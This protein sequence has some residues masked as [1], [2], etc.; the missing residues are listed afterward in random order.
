EDERPRAEPGHERR[1]HRTDGVGG[2]AEDQRQLAGP[3]TLID[4]R[5]CA[6]DEQQEED[7]AREGHAVLTVGILR[8]GGR[9]CHSPASAGNENTRPPLHTRRQS[10]D[11]YR[12]MPGAPWYVTSYRRTLLDM[13]IDDRDASFLSRVDPAAYVDL[14]ARARVRSVML[15]ANSHVGLCYWPTR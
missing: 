15:Y 4:Q 11:S 12:P 10:G 3:E 9:P 2:G 14:L 1:Q 7:D 5:H 8:H 6:R 13:H